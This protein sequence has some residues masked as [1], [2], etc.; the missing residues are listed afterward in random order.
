[1]GRP[2]GSASS[3]MFSP[4]SPSGGWP[5]RRTLT[6]SK[7]PRWTSNLGLAT[8]CTENGWGL[9]NHFQ[10][11]FAVAGL[12]AVIAMDFVIWLQ[13]VMVHAVPLMLL[14]HGLS[15][16]PGIDLLA[17]H[18]PGVPCIRTVPGPPCFSPLPG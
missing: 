10:A 7:A 3:L 15:P 14:V 12:L 17:S 16:Q 18:E 9:F 11:P 1:M 13:H 2:F 6:V 5:P 4:L 8:L